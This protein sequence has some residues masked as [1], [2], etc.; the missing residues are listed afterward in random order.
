MAQALEASVSTERTWIG[1]ELMV[2]SVV[3]ACVGLLGVLSAERC[4]RGGVSELYALHVT[5]HTSSIVHVWKGCCST[6]L[7]GM[8]HHMF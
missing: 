6:C 4:V 7:E 5:A 3:R 2:E 1:L 8:L